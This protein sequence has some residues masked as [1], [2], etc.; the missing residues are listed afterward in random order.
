MPHR[1][2]HLWEKIGTPENIADAWETFNRNRKPALRREYSKERAD[3]ILAELRKIAAGEESTLFKEVRHK[4]IFEHGKERKL[5]IPS[6]RSCIG[7]QALLNHLAPVIDS[8]LHGRTYS[9][10]KGWGMHKCA[11]KQQKFI[12]TKIK[13]SKYFLYFDIRKF[14]EHIRH[15][16]VVKSIERIVKDKAVIRI[17]RAVVGATP[18]G[19]PIGF[20]GSHH[21][22]NLLLTPLYYLIR[23]VEKV[24]D[25]YVYM[26]NFIV[27]GRTKRSLHIAQGEAEAW[28]AEF[29]MSMKPDWQIAPVDFR[30]ISTCG[31]KIGRKGTPKLYPKLFCR[32]CRGMAKFVENPTPHLAR[33]LLSRYGWLK[34]VGRENLLSDVVP[35]DY[36]KGKAK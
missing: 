6:L 25:C 5:E 2:G 11:K 30:P 15:E 13:D 27:Y 4:T 23:G 32:T 9:S 3:E 26:D 33:S 20:T 31:V 10:R 24:T 14:Y 8:R 34:L 35:L 29:G 28:L 16:D 17:V 19:L 7:Q 18:Q 22:A 12:R 21:F 1:V 36:V